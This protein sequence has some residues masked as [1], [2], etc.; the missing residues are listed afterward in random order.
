MRDRS[1]ASM[2]Q[3]NW[4]LIRDAASGSETARASL[5]AVMKRAWPAVYAFIRASGRKSEEATELTQAFICDVFLARRLLEK[6][7]QAR[8]RF[9]TLLLGAVRN[10]LAD[11][12]RRR[13]AT[14]RM[15]KSG[16]IAID[17]AGEYGMD[18]AD[19][20][21]GDS[22]ER[23]FNARYVA[24]LVRTAGER[25]H[26]ELQADGDAA[27]WELFRARVLQAAFQGD[28]P[29]YG[30]LAPR[31][32]LERGQC[33]AKLLVVKRR[34]SVLL[35]EELRATVSDPDAVREEVDDLLALLKAR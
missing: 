17:A 1:H 15:P 16:L 9:R 26:R 31:L 8:G 12:H 14:T 30:T 4:D 35:M 13:T 23:A 32:G 34:F 25:L 11:V 2:T 20:A 29:G 33:A 27:G 10:Y 21:T 6:A 3:T 19:D 5:D 22:P 18:V 24:G 7:D 28:A